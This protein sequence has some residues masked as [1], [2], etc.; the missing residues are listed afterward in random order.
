MEIRLY[1]LLKRLLAVATLLLTIACTDE[2]MI[3][4]PETNADNEP[5]VIHATIASTGMAT[6]STNPDFTNPNAS[7]GPIKNRTLLFTYP[8]AKEGGRMRSLPCVFNANGYG[9]IKKEDGNPLLWGDIDT[10]K[11]IYK[12]DDN[13]NKQLVDVIENAVVYLDNLINYP[14]QDMELDQSV[15]SGDKEAYYKVVDN[16]T[17]LRFSK[18]QEYDNVNKGIF[19]Q[20]QTQGYRIM[21]AIP[22][23]AR[24]DSLVDIIWSS[25]SEPEA[26]KVLEFKLE[27]KMSAISFRFS[28]DDKDLQD[29]LKQ[30]DIQVW[31]DNVRVCIGH[32]SIRHSK[33]GN[34][35]DRKNGTVYPNPGASSIAQEDV[36]LIYENYLP[37]VIYNG[38]KEE[39]QMGAITDRPTKGGILYEVQE[40]GL[41]YYSTPVWIFPPFQYVNSNNI[42]NLMSRPML[43][44]D[45]GSKQGKFNGYFPTMVDY[46]IKNT[47]GDYT[48]INDYLSFKAGYHLIFNVKLKKEIDNNEIV[49]QNIEVQDMAYSFREDILAKQSGIY[50]WKDLEELIETYNND[51]SEKN[52]RLQRYGS[53]SKPKWVFVLWRDIYV[54]DGKQTENGQWSKFDNE[55][56][57]IKRE[58]TS[59]SGNYGIYLNPTITDQGEITSK[60]TP[61]SDEALTNTQNK[62]NL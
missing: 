44:I 35:F 57:E 5:V 15:T 27:H 18:Q 37:D 54:N 14:A 60:G 58:A 28:S 40:S 43:T 49:F 8:S 41:T 26:G 30:T 53:Y 6:K 34:P 3:S 33:E 11:L 48:S 51:S 13:S 24:A 39:P 2:A 32:S 25:I 36:H 19:E 1:T 61:L 45:L 21:I 7:A 56:F 59:D 4:A 46:L 17:K 10:E 23:T 42:D 31:L 47:N 16:F 9:T 52:Y 38:A 12:K 62:N 22:G 29:A 20:N 55:K 50:K